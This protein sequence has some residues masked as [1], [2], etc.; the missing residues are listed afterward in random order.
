MNLGLLND[1]GVTVWQ[2]KP[3]FQRLGLTHEMASD[4]EGC[5]AQSVASKMP[6]LD[7]IPAAQP[8][9]VLLG[10]G[11]KPLWQQGNNQAWLLWQAMIHFHLESPQ[12]MMFFDTDLLHAE[13]Q[14]FDVLEQIIETGVERIFTM[15][16]EHPINEML[17]EGAQLIA[18]PRFEQM[19]AQPSLKCEVYKALSEAG[20]VS[21]Y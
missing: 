5:G 9:W 7:Q 18:I 19:L 15:D 14:Q 21:K 16:T 6:N 17:M 4:S 3:G 11:L 10:A 8:Y 1:L 20:L 13:D 12:K 2:A